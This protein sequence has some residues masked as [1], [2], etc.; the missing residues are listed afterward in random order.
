MV[1]GY[2][3]KPNVT[4]RGVNKRKEARSIEARFKIDGMPVL[5][6]TEKEARKAGAAFRRH[7][8]DKIRGNRERL[9]IAG[10]VI[11]PTPAA[12]ETASQNKGRAAR[13]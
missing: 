4:R 11:P 1:Q 3:T 13:K 10:T 12:L 6:H 7:V 8:E 5:V 2:Y 9:T